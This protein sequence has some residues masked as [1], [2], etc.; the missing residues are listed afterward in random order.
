M[1]SFVG[2]AI[3]LLV[4]AIVKPAR[5]EQGGKQDGNRNLPELC[6]PSR[7][8]T[9]VPELAAALRPL[10]VSRFSRCKSVRIS[11]ALW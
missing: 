11:A 2:Q 9:I 1:V 10:S 8:P 5:H 3:A 7:L 4:R 6:N